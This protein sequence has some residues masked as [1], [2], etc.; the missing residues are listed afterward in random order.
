MSAIESSVQKIGRV[1]QV[2][3][4]V[5]D[6]SFDDGQLLPAINSALTLTNSTIDDKEDNLVLEVSLHVGD[7]TVRCVSMDSTEGLVRGLKVKDTGA[8]I[9]VPVGAKTLG[10]IMDVVG[11]PVDQA[12]EIDAEVR[13]PIHRAAPKFEDQ[14]TSKEIFETGIKVIDLLA[15]YVKGGKIGLFGGAGVGKT[16]IIMELIN[17]VAKAHGGYSVFAGVGERTREGNDLWH[18]MKDS[19][20]LDKATLVY[21]QMNEPPGA[22]FRVALSALTAA[23][24]FRDEEHRDVLLFVDNIFRFVQA[25]SEVSALLGRMP[26][27]V[28]Y[29]PTLATDVGELQE[30]ITSTKNGSITSVQAVYVP[31]D[32]LTDPAPATTFAHLDA[33]TVLSRAIAEQGIYPA[34]DPLASNSSILDPMILGEEHYNVAREVQST[35]QRYKD[36]QDI[37]AILGMDELSEEDK[38]VVERARKIQRF[39]S[40]PFF[41]AEQFTGLAGKFVKLEDT[42]RGFKELVQGKHDDL[43]EQAFYLVGTI[44]EARA[45]AERLAAEAN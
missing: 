21:G 42:I 40:Q 44:E 22:R 4:P 31:A 6:V 29:Q 10:R 14:S 41:V 26:S 38:L 39:L 16:V 7:N 18:E 37:I 15:P 11:R 36:L 43:P 23:E 13:W 3:G 35:L 30:R 12:G 32:D 8:P 45:K 17:N 28:G 19:G 9:M 27:A 33:T 2:L 24:Y 25:G 20:V 1:V 5:V 34:V